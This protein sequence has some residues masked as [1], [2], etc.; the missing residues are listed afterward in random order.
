MFEDRRSATATIWEA[1]STE[2]VLDDL[3]VDRPG[4]WMCAVL[5]DLRD[6]VVTDI[7]REKYLRC[8]DRLLPWL[9]LRRAEAVV[10]AASSQASVVGPFGVDDFG[11]DVIALVT[12]QTAT[13]AATDLVTARCIT[14][15][16]NC[17]YGALS[18]GDITWQMAREVADGT[19]R[20]T[21]WQRE[22]VDQAMVAAWEIDNDITKW[23]RKLRREVF[24]VDENADERR[25]RAILERD[26]RSWPL[27]D[28]MACV[29]AN[30]R[31]EDAAAVMGALNGIAAKY[32]A[33]DQAAARAAGS[34]AGDEWYDP[35]AFD[36]LPTERV[37]TRAQARADALVDAFDDLLATGNLPKH[38]GR[39]TT[40]NAT[41]GIKTIL[42][43]ANNPGEL[44][45]YG[46]ITAEHLRELAADA[47]WRRFTTAP[48]TGA[49]IGIGTETYRP[50]QALR[51]FLTA[52]EP[53]CDF[54]GCGIP[55]HRC[56]GEHTRSHTAGGATDQDNLRPRCRRHHRCKTHAGWLVE[57]LPDGAT[58]WTTPGGTRRIILPHRQA[59]DDD[60]DDDDLGV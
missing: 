58:A 1:A 44:L 7:E 4:P 51:D 35:D 47:R 14:S 57:R 56:D 32:R 22:Q 31:A 10:G 50:G 60:D 3:L 28:G 16:L 8:W 40:V 9:Q 19:S 25:R 26:V 43:L 34:D 24:K 21:P 53:T 30:L 45:G 5:E 20:L 6:H 38:Q 36:R 33:Q 54:P 18:R 55:A 46:P 48:D 29:N 13:T 42:G 37:R 27:P 41:G 52:V 12:G 39:A 59:G 15:E 11:A 49:L 17:V 2:A 23:R